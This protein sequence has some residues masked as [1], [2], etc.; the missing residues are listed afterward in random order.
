MRVPP[1]G[2]FGRLEPRTHTRR[3]GRASAGWLSGRDVER[4][5]RSGLEQ[6]KFDTAVPE[7]AAKLAAVA[8]LKKLAADAGVPLTH[9]ALAFVRAHPAVTSVII[10]PRTREHLDDLVVGADVVL[11]D[12]VLERI[13]EIVPPGTDLN[14][15]DSYYVPPALSDPTLRRRRPDAR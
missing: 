11:D 1:S 7:N 5:R 13:D 4:S 2:V 10:G 9:L 14:R 8:E 15:A 6:R 12:A 3:R